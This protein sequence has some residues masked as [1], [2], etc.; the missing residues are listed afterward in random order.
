MSSTSCSLISWNVNGIRAVQK[1]GFL[2][3]LSATSPDIVCLQET[4]A[5]VDQLGDEL[6]HPAGYQSFWS[7]GVR[8][9]YSGV[10]TYTRQPPLFTFS[11]FDD[12]FLQ[13]EGRIMLTEHPA[14]FLF[15]VYFPNGGS[16][17][18]R[19]EYKMAFY[20]AF[21]KEAELYRK[22]KPVIICGDMNTAHAERDLSRPKEN[23]KTSGFLLQERAWIDALIGCGYID[24]F[25]M[26]EQD[27]EH[28]SWWDM[29]TGARARNVG[30][31]I[32][33]FFVSEELRPAVKRAWIAPDVMGSDH[34]PVGLDLALS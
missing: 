6:I 25:R 22:K 2:D 21:L 24:T 14:F 33:Y 17:P 23:K 5:H 13:G 8:R 10:V 30:W 16:G 4:K 1:K 19:L 28:Y 18:E 9:G 29:K 27:G 20:D 3:W 11:D 26:F 12:P 15:N 31:R 7:S 32:D 34:C